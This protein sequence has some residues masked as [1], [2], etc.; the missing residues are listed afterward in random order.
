MRR[1]ITGSLSALVF[2]A[3]FFVTSGSA[4]AQYPLQKT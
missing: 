3:A 2:C 1:F 4:S